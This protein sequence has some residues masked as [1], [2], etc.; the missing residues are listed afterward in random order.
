MD[1]PNM[2]EFAQVLIPSAMLLY[3]TDS[4]DRELVDTIVNLVL[5]H[6]K[7]IVSADSL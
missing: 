1:S 6:S 5:C 4:W 7:I 3:T 2:N